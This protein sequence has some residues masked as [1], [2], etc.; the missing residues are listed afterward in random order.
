MQRH[1]ITCAINR[2]KSTCGKKGRRKGSLSGFII[3]RPSNSAAA[4]CQALT[5]DPSI[6]MIACTA[7]F[8]LLNKEINKLIN[9]KLE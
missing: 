4:Q 8:S 2:E 7:R 6:P 3:K 5:A 1:Y 9:H